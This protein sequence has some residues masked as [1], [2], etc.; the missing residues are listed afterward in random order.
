[1]LV[2][3]LAYFEWDKGQSECRQLAYKISQPAVSYGEGASRVPPCFCTIDADIDV[4]VDVADC[5]RGAMT[6]RPL[7]VPS[8]NKCCRL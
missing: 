2:T 8:S 7:V 5:V 3:L 4:D 1:M 6:R